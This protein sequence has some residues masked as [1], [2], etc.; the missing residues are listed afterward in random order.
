MN[1]SL[2][3]TETVLHSSQVNTLK[4]VGMESAPLKGM[5]KVLMLSKN[6][7][8]LGTMHTIVATPNYFSYPLFIITSV[9]LNFSMMEEKC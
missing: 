5:S 3:I 8:S 4:D 2:E 1:Q 6:R 7:G 9:V